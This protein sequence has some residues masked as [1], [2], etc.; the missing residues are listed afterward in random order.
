MQ[1]KNDSSSNFGRKTKVESREHAFKTIEK[2]PIEW[3]HGATDLDV[4]IV[5]ITNS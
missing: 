1:R 2:K 3:N 4:K 5:L